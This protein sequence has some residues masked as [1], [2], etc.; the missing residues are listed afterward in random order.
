MRKFRSTTVIKNINA[1]IK[2]VFNW[3]TDYQE[4]DPDITGS[5]R[6]RIV[7]D[8]SKTRVV[9]AA[10]FDE[11]GRTHVSVYDVKLKPPGSW[12]YDI[13]D[14]DRVGTGDYKLKRLSSRSTELRIIFR[15]RY[16]NPTKMESVQEYTGRLNTLWDKYIA[17]LEKEYVDYNH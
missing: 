3:C 1:P 17:A 9:Y 2:F 8:R 10:L 13:F 15:N 6:K 12:H 5:K 4:T 11:D 7:L 14:P 16:K